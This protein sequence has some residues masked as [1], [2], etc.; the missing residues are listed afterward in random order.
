MKLARARKGGTCV[1]LAEGNDGAWHDL[2]GLVPD[3]GPETMAQVLALTPELVDAAPALVGSPEL[4]TPLARPGKLL[5]IG[6]NYTDHADEANMPRPAEPICFMKALSSIAGPFDDL[7]LPPGSQKSDWEVELGIVIG[8]TAKH[9]AEADALAHVAGYT[10][11]NDVSERAY[12]L[13]RGGQWAKGKSYDGFAPMGPWFVTADEVGDPQALSIW[14]D[15][16]G[17]RMQDGSTADMIF[18]VARIVSYM[19]DFMTLE[20]GD[21]IATGTPA[22]VGMGRGVFLKPGDV[23]EAGVEKLGVQ[24][25]K[26]AG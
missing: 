12:Q 5:C 7:A 14:L 15:V 4:V 10:V 19:S 26:V 24:R 16:N 1:P 8:T 9:V 6:L 21:V 13:E 17:E 23:M 11:V 18:T 3:I 20:P 2:S 25:V 22:G